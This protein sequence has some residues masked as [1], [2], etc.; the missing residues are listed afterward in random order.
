MINTHSFR[1][2]GITKLSR[3]DPNFAKKL[4]G[5]KGYLLKYDRMTNE[6]KLAIYQKFEVDLIIDDSEKQK[7][8]IQAL[9]EEK[10]ELEQVNGKLKELQKEKDSLGKKYRESLTNPLDEA[11]TK[12]I[13]EIL[14]KH[15]IK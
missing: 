9:Q 4:A 14:K 5:Q 7:A 10:S 8:E 12:R 6:E 15:N 11:I 1:A 3:H 13:D 2:Y